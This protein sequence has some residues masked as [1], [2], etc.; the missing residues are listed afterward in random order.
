MLAKVSSCYTCINRKRTYSMLLPNL[1]T[2]GPL[3]YLHWPPGGQGPHFG[4]HW[5][6]KLA[7]DWPFTGKWGGWHAAK[8]AKPQVRLEPWAAAGQ[9]LCTWHALPTEILERPIYK[10]RSSSEKLCFYFR[11]AVP[12][13]KDWPALASNENPHQPTIVVPGASLLSQ[14]PAVSLCQEISGCLHQQRDRAAQHSHHCWVS[15]QDTSKRFK[16]VLVSAS[17][18]C[19]WIVA[20]KSWWKGARCV[21]S[22]AQL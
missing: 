8:P 11:E 7:Y 1:N 18:V 13:L 17:H 12:Y 5:S 22:S 6:T 21:T 2:N 20:F 3:A 4:S 19:N 10:G 9:S 14:P 15:G 16:S